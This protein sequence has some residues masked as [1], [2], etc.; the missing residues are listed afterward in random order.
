MSPG[1]VRQ[2]VVLAGGLGTR[3]GELTQATPKPLLPVGGRPFLAYLLDW[4]ARGGVEEIIVSTGY[5]PDAFG[6]FFAASSWRNPYGEPVR[7]YEARENVRAGTAGAL[8]L[9]ANRLDDRFLLVNGD[10]FFDCDLAGVIGAAERLPQG[11][12]LLTVREVEDTGRYGRVEIGDAGLILSFAHRGRSGAG[13]I[14]AGISV[15]DRSV[16]ELIK[17]VPCSLEQDVY[18]RVAEAGKLFSWEQQGYFIDIG[19]PETYARA[20]DELPAQCTKPAAFFDRDGVLNVDRGYTHR[21]DDLEFV[22]GAIEAVQM[23]RAAGY[24]AVVVTNQ[25]GVAKGYYDEAAVSAFHRTLNARLREKGAWIDAFYYCPYHPEASV[26]AFRRA[27]PDRKP[28]PGMI[29]RAIEELSIDSARSF[30]IGDQ[31]TDLEAARRAGI[32]GYLYSSGSVAELVAT[33]LTE[34]PA[35]TP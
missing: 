25:A 5:L 31:Q 27:H 19:L 13:L 33:A 20:Q 23:A 7:V 6:A 10:T 26:A 16:L 14:N 29:L 28:E 22:D 3:L 4:L 30:L 17:D 8:A 2:A 15:L 11:S 12:M 32:R 18:P 9:M 21:L 24:L 1:A 35:G 34:R